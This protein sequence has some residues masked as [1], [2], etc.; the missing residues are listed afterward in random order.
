M[1]GDSTKS[2]SVSA[3]EDVLNEH[4]MMKRMFACNAMSKFDNSEH[5]F[6]DLMINIWNH[7]VITFYESFLA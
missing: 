3:A 2:F 6:E 4:L 7:D 5:H 1:L